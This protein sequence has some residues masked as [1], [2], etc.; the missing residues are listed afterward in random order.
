[1]TTLNGEIFARFTAYETDRRITSDRG[2]VAG[3]YATT[4]ADADRVST[5]S[6]AVERYALPDPAPAIYRFTII[7][8]YNT[9]YRKGVVQPAFG[10]AGGG[11]EVLFDDATGPN[12]VRGPRILPP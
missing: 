12:T 9:R 10:H 3:T 1:M 11:I 7:P 2:L 8:R 6:H 5:G 4:A